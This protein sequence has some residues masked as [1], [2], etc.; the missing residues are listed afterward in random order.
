MMALSVLTISLG[1]CFDDPTGPS[2]SGCFDYLLGEEIPC[3][4]PE[5]KK[6]LEVTTIT[7][8]EDIDPDGYPCEIIQE[9]YGTTWHWGGSCVSR[10]SLVPP[11]SLRVPSNT[12]GVY[13]SPVLLEQV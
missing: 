8:G 11:A 1:G 4:T 5:M 12:A 3:P 2:S 9:V 7:T 10:P 13:V 6:I